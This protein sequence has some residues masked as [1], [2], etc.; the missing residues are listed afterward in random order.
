MR[1][2]AVNEWNNSSTAKPMPTGLVKGKGPP[3]GIIVGVFL[4]N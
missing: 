3:G 4:M 1:G 2:L